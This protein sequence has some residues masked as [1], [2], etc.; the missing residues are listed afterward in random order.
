MTDVSCSAVLIA[1]NE[2][3]IIEGCL[4]SVRDLA[5]EIVVLDTG[6]TDQTRDRARNLGARVVESDWRDDFAKARNEAVSHARGQWILSIDADERIMRGDREG[7][8]LLL[9]DASR[10]AYR[11][12]LRP[13]AAFTPFRHCRLFRNHRDIRFEGRIRESVVPSLRRLADQQASGHASNRSSFDVLVGDCD[14]WIEH[15]D[16]PAVRHRKHGRDLPLLRQAIQDDDENALYWTD[17]GRALAGVGDSG[18]ALTAWQRA[19]ELVRRRGS[20]RPTDS[21]PYTDVLQHRTNDGQRRALLDEASARFPQN[22]LLV[23]LRAESLVAERRFEVAEPL[24]RGLASIDGERDACPDLAYDRRIFA[25]F[26]YLGL[27]TCCVGAGRWAEA[28]EWYGLAEA[29]Q[30]SSLEY[31]A[32]RT[33]SLR[34]AGGGGRPAGL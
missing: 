25:E 19:I 18:G 14:A 28:A 34:R 16:D 9:S 31:R 24:L 4:R 33:L 2:E 15:H 20:G 23:W 7:L 32:K 12:W 8:R 17:L 30:P 11:L 21:L 27:A 10:V 22:H 26:A 6:S 5:D 13:D 1:R 29:A 3:A